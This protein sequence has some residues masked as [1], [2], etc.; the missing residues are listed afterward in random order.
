VSEIVDG[1]PARVDAD[2]VF[3]DRLQR[4][5]PVGERVVEANVEMILCGHRTKHSS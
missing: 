5:E 4:L 3:M 1:R 2:F